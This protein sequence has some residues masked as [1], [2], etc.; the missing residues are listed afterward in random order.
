MWKK[1]GCGLIGIAGALALLPH[2]VANKNFAHDN[3]RQFRCTGVNYLFDL[4]AEKCD[5][6]T[7]L[8]DRC[9]ELNVVLKP[10]ERDFHRREMK[11]Q[12]ATA[13]RS[14]EGYTFERT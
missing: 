4:E 6:T 1:I 14:G 7:N 5:G 12:D 2:A 3:L 10:V 9:R 13:L 8:I 11:R